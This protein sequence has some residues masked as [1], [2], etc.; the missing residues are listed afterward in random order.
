[1]N[2]ALLFLP[3]VAAVGW[4]IASMIFNSGLFGADMIFII[5]RMFGK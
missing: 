1:M 2:E 5:A 3:P 4:F